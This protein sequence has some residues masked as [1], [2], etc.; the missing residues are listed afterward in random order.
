MEYDLPY[1]GDLQKALERGD[2]S[3]VEKIML[4]RDNESISFSLPNVF[5]NH[6]RCEVEIIFLDNKGQ[7]S[8]SFCGKLDGLNDNIKNSNVY[9]IMNIRLK[10][11]LNDWYILEDDSNVI[12]TSKV[13]VGIFIENN[14]YSFVDK[15]DYD[16]NYIDL[17]YSLY[18]RMYWKLNNRSANISYENFRKLSESGMIA[19]INALFRSSPKR[20]KNF[21]PEE[22][23][24]EFEVDTLYDIEE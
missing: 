2:D 15:L 6:R 13:I 22:E 23:D 10:K 8:N 17:Y 11:I 1:D 20:N 12:N 16:K 4:Y 14:V 18:T 19:V 24:M 21:T 7:P 5:F 9:F 3:A